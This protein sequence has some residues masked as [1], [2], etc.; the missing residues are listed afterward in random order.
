MLKNCRKS[1]NVGVATRLYIMFNIKICPELRK[2]IIKTKTRLI[3][4]IFF[5]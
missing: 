2:Q 1:N 5:F 4:V 3:V